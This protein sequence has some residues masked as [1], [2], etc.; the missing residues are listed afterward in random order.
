VRRTASNIIVG[1]F[2]AGLLS[3]I[4]GLFALNASIFPGKNPSAV[5]DRLQLKFT[6]ASEGLPVEGIWKSSPALLKSDGSGGL[7]FAA[8]ALD[9][10]GPH[11][12]KRDAGGNWADA[13]HAQLTRD[14]C[15]GSVEFGEIKKG[16]SPIMAVAD[17]CTGVSVYVDD[18]K[19]RWTTLVENLNP[20]IADLLGKQ[21]ATGDSNYFLGA[22]GVALGDVN[23]DGSIDIVAASAQRGGLT[24]Y[25]GDGAGGWNEVK[26]TGLP[27]AEHV[28]PDDAVNGGRANQVKLIDINGDGHLDVVA[29][30]FKGPS[31]WV[32]DGKGNFREQSEGLPRP[33]MGG[34]YFK[35]AV[36]DINGD[37]LP[38]LVFANIVNGVEIYTQK[39]DGS[40]QELPDVFPSLMGGATAVALADLTGDGH[41]DL[42][43]A[44]RKGNKPGDSFGLFVLKGD[45]KGGFKEIG[46]NLPADGLPIIW[47]LE[48][49]TKTPGRQQIIVTTGSGPRRNQAMF[50]PGIPAKPAMA[51]HSVSEKT[52]PKILV[53]QNATR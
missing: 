14:S 11:V 36:G 8:L 15:G 12:W 13:F 48:V 5:E 47:G 41:L 29:S 24:L 23:E 20:E 44:G 38:D 27:T 33:S 50:Q 30:Y 46:T 45:G 18:G 42:I 16:G 22:E 25:L 4:G 10:D 9:G 6:S 52:T 31:V 53:W 28:E 32:G 19:G 37:G 35:F 7:E 39:P 2:L 26:A 21:G 40:W 43:V 51:N 1:V 49:D 34:I 3:F 17:H